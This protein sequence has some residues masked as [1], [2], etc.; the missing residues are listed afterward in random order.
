MLDPILNAVEVWLS[1][2]NWLPI[3]IRALMELSLFGFSI[4]VI[5]NLI[6]RIRS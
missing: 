4:S 3:P 2:Y 5:Y 1:F 6:N